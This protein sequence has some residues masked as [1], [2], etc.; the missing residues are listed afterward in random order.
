M[1][2]LCII[3][4]SGFV[5]FTNSIS[6]HKDDIKKGTNFVLILLITN[7]ISVGISATLTFWI[8]K[9]FERPDEPKIVVKLESI[10]LRQSLS[11]KICNGEIVLHVSNLENKPT[12]LM[13]DT[14]HLSI[15]E[16]DKRVFSIYT[17]KR[18]PL[19]SYEN[20]VDTVFFELVDRK[21]LD[22]TVVCP[23][24]AMFFNV[25]YPTERIA[26][27][28]KF[29]TT[30][31]KI[32]IYY[33]WPQIPDSAYYMMRYAYSHNKAPAGWRRID[34][35]YFGTTYDCYYYLVNDEVNILRSGDLLKIEFTN[36]EYQVIN[37][38]STK[39]ESNFIFMAHP[40]IKDN[41]VNLDMYDMKMP[42]EQRGKGISIIEK[43]FVVKRGYIN[44]LYMVY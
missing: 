44:A 38:D 3:L 29:D 31:S 41:F 39:F 18:V 22:T 43:R 30:Q 14:L 33:N 21:I 42:I 37:V 2:R 26:Q 24:M 25:C 36:N 23:N 16:I 27:E 9:K 40:K 8:A 6:K 5:K 34:I 4:K 1:K 13:I 12:F 35:G 32:T 15:P 19:I 28:I 20:K 11:S 10:T 7:V 17:N